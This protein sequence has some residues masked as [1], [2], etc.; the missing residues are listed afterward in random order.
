MWYH[1]RVESPRFLIKKLL[2]LVWETNLQDVVF[3]FESE[4]KNVH[5]WILW[6][7]RFLDLDLDVINLTLS[8]VRG[9]NG[10]T[11]N[12]AKIKNK[13]TIDE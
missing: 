12:F 4:R 8:K 13:Q 10:C 2:F 9:P 5:K 7:S 1:I 6:T 3:N 11:I